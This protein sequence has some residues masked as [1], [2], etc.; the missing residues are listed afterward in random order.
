MRAEFCE[1]G[2][3]ADLLARGWQDAGVAA[4]LTW[5]RRL[6]MVRLAQRAW[7]PACTEVALGGTFR[8]DN[9]ID[10]WSCMGYAGCH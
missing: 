2:S 6:S 3:L 10:D 8:S 7:S 4:Q 9:F 5:E 1:R